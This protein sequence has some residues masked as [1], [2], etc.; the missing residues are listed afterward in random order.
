METQQHNQECM[1]YIKVSIMCTT[2]VKVLWVDNSSAV[3]HSWGANVGEMANI[4]KQIMA[5]FVS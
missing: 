3:L 5:L 4:Y 2:F 1:M